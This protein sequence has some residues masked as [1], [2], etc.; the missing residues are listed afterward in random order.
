M[1]QPYPIQYPEYQ[2]QQPYAQQYAPPVSAPPP[3][4]ATPALPPRPQGSKTATGPVPTN[5]WWQNLIVEAGDQPVVTSPYMI[6]S[7]TGAHVPLVRGMPFV[8][9]EFTSP[10]MLHLTTV[11]AIT[12]VDVQNVPQGCAVVSLND[13]RTWLVCCEL[14]VG[15]RQD[16]MSA[17]VS[18]QPVTGAVRI[19]L[20]RKAIPVGG[21]ATFTVSWQTRSG[22]QPLLCAFPIGVGQ[23]WSTKGPMRAVRGAQ[24]QWTEQIEPLGFAGPLVK[25]DAQA[26][27]PIEHLPRDPYFFGKAAAR[28]ARIALIADEIGEPATRRLRGWSHG[29]VG[30]NA[31]PLVFDTE[32]HGLISTDGLHDSNADFGQGRYNDHH[33]H[34]G[35]FAD[36]HFPAMRNFDFFDGHFPINAYYAAYLYALATGRTQ[37]AWYVRAILQLEARTSRIYWHVGDIGSSIYPDTYS[38]DKAIVGILWA[39][40]YDFA[41]FFSAD[42]ACIYGIQFLPYTPAT[43]LLLKRSWVADIWPKYLQK[44]WREI[45]E[46][47]GARTAHITSHDDGNSGIQL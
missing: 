23:Y 38:N 30:R 2:Q 32:W 5:A 12:N 39:G 14:P 29:S 20:A 3:E 40:K 6:K 9:A 18:D 8:T 16:G 7:Y 26:L 17:V 10:A 45:I 31:N 27:P 24:W 22:D 11:H 19:A 37:L 36:G 41:T 1:P 46:L 15:L 25:T 47:A 28:A 4:M 35:Y 33:F 42:P 34:Y 43:A 13:G 44:P 21:S